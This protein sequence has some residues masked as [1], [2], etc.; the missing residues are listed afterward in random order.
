MRKKTRTHYHDES[1]YDETLLHQNA[2]CALP[3]EECRPTSP[4]IDMISQEILW[5]LH[6]NT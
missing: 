2:I 1:K 6:N 4:A 5:D 3:L